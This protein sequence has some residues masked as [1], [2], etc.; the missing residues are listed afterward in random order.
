[1][2]VRWERTGMRETR[3]IGESPAGLRRCFP[4]PRRHGIGVS[5]EALARCPG[6]SF[7]HL[8]AGIAG[9][10]SLPPGQAFFQQLVPHIAPVMQQHLGRHP[11]LLVSREPSHDNVTASHVASNRVL[12]LFPIGLLEFWTIDIFKV[13]RLAPPIVMD[14]ETIALMDGDDS[15]DK[16]SP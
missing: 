11:T 2:W 10:R 16:V 5:P 3:L 15:R 13:N 12:R 1:M 9:G 4:L 6:Q 14:R 8:E 7:E